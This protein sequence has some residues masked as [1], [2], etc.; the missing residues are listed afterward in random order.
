MC[1]GGGGAGADNTRTQM[2]LYYSANGRSIQVHVSLQV[3]AQNICAESMSRVS[4]IYR[5]SSAVLKRCFD[6]HFR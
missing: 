2:F 4:E 1:V 3:T 5:N 6:E